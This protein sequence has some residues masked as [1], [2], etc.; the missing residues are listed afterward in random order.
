MEEE[1]AAVS[2][3]VYEEVKGWQDSSSSVHDYKKRLEELVPEDA[4]VGE[5][6]EV[7]DVK[8][9]ILPVE[10]LHVDGY[11]FVSL[12][13]VI[14]ESAQPSSAVK[15]E[16]PIQEPTKLQKTCI[17]KHHK[18]ELP[19]LSVVVASPLVQ[20]TQTSIR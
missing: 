3:N 5:N 6:H 7:F 10:E 14:Q 12:L 1:R 8:T 16:S 11:S 2:L 18:Q 19:Q 13:P 15:A 17:V 20:P 9:N 4:N